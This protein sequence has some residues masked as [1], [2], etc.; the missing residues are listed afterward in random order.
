[1]MIP[2]RVCKA[3]PMLAGDG[4]GRGM[5]NVEVRRDAD[6]RARATAT[7]GHRLLT[8]AWD[9]A[10]D[11]V[12]AT[13]GDGATVKG[14]RTLL[15]ADGFAGAARLL[16]LAKARKAGEVGRRVLLEEPTANGTVRLSATDYESVPAVALASRTADTQFPNWEPCVRGP[17]PDAS[18]RIG[19]DVRLLR[20]TLQALEALGVGVVALDMLNP[21]ASVRLTPAGWADDATDRP[22]VVAVIMPVTLADT[23][24]PA[25]PSATFPAK[26]KR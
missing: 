10:A 12:P 25:T 11:A 9:D 6:G 24:L 23:K 1:M 7:D 22:E 20:E 8:V 17:S 19:L 4:I 13:M 2:T 5:D 26:R 16:P 3:V 14:F 18:H 21:G 15:P